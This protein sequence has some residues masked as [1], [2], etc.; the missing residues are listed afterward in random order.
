MAKTKTRSHLV[1]V[2]RVK[3]VVWMVPITQQA[4]INIHGSLIMHKAETN[5][6]IN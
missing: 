5:V 2:Q 6:P 4:G 1:P 3:A